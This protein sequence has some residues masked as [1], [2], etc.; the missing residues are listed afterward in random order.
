MTMRTSVHINLRKPHLRTK[1]RKLLRLHLCCG[2]LDLLIPPFPTPPHLTLLMPAGSISLQA[3]LIGCSHLAHKVYVHVDV[4]TSMSRSK[5]AAASSTLHHIVG[6]SV[7]YT[8]FSAPTTIPAA[9]PSMMAQMMACFIIVMIPV[10]LCG[11][12]TSMLTSCAM[13]EGQCRR[14]FMTYSLHISS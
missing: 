9:P 2:H 5:I 1:K 12:C 10:F 8:V 14:M 13:M 3:S 7:P 4:N 11:C 6:A